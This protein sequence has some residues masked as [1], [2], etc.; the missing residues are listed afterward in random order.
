MYKVD[1]L[2]VERNW[3]SPDYYA[4]DDETQPITVTQAQYNAIKA[5]P[6]EVDV[7]TPGP[8]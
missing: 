8:R 3:G 5:I 4:G 6:V 7:I 1:R 2:Y